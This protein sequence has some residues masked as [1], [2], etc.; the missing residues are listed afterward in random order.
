MLF[1]KH[2]YTESQRSAT[3]SM[4]PVMNAYHQSDTLIKMITT[5]RLRFSGHINCI[6]DN[7]CAKTALFW[8]PS[9]GKRKQGRPRITWIKNFK[10]DLEW[11]GTTWDEARTLAKD[12][13]VNENCLLPDVQ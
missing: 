5:R 6:E 7:R 13:D 10:N 11:A 3:E 9:N 1:M 8:V 12:R 2:V 4:S